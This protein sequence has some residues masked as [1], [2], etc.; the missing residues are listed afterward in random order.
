[1]QAAPTLQ[2]AY[3]SVSLLA[4]PGWARQLLHVAAVASL[5]FDRRIQH[6][7]WTTMVFILPEMRVAKT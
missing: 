7:Q 5:K 4:T 3:L 6:A 2:N 1:M